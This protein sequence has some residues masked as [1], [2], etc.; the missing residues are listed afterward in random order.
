MAKYLGELELLMVDKGKDDHVTTFK[1]LHDETNEIREVVFFKDTYDSEV[2]EFKPDADQYEKYVKNLET[3]LHVTPDTVY[4]AVGKKF[5]V[6]A[7]EKYDYMWEPTEFYEFPTQFKGQ[8]FDAV[9][10]DIWY[11]ESKEGTPQE[12]TRV[13]FVLKLK[14]HGKLVKSNM[15]WGE[16]VPS[17]KRSFSNP[18]KRYMQMQNFEE[19]FGVLFEN[20][21]EI[22]GKDV[23]IE[24]K[25]YNFNGKSGTYVDI[26]PFPKELPFAL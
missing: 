6:W 24:V 9:I 10:E 18:R 14:E 7:G 1:F 20:R 26:K 11:D 2:K 17:L 4:D 16:W 21:N 15:N 8:N 22:I 25:S 19:K 12:Q 3:Y 23:K 13:T 5:P